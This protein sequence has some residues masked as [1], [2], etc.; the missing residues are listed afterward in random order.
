MNTH[1]YSKT[2]GDLESKP[3][4][5]TFNFKEHQFIFHTDAGVFSKDYIDYGSFAMLKIFKPNNL[6]YPILDMG[7]GYGPIGIVVSKLYNK[8]TVM[9]EINERAYNLII[10]NIKQNNSDS[11]AYHSD[12]FEKIQDMKFSSV[13]TNPPIRAGKDVVYA[14]YDGAYDHLVE[15]GELWVVIQ[16]KQGA[17]SSKD[18]LEKLFGNCEIVNRDKGYYILKSI[19]KC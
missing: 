6:E 10:K 17:P 11:E 14:I 9:C 18:H 8:K 1:Y 13:I 4:Q 2:Q 16:K 15:N 7:A 19:K 5:Y 12:L 3:S